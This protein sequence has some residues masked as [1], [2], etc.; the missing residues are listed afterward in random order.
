MASDN[1]GEA[2][3]LEELH[4]G[5]LRHR[6]AVFAMIPMLSEREIAIPN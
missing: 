3:N 4:G 2:A 6:Q 1:K 5:D